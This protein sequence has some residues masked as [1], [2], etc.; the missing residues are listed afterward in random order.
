MA[1]T[2]A[3]LITVPPGTRLWYDDRDVALLQQDAADDAAIV[4]ENALSL[5]ALIRAGF[6]PDTATEAIITGSF[7]NLVHSGLVSV[8][9]L[10]PGEGEEQ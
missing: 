8:Q 6:I 9:L 1:E 5:E 7:E 3:P 4:K 10:P 2:F